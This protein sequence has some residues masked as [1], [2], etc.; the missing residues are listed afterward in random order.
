MHCIN[1]DHSYTI[2]VWGPGVACSNPLGGSR[3]TQ[4]FILP[5]SIRWVPGTSRNFVVKSKLPP[6]S[7][8]VALN[9]LN[10]IHKKGAIKLFFLS[11]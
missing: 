1:S 3:S 6:G 4:L 10:P 11:L 7:G 8:S 9:D 5:R 2:I